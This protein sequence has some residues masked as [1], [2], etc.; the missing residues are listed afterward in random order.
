MEPD[1]SLS[2]GHVMSVVVLRVCVLCSPVDT[3]VCN[4][5]VERLD[6]ELSVQRV[7]LQQQVA[8]VGEEQAAW[9]EGFNGE[10]RGRLDGLLERI[11]ER[12]DGQIAQV[13]DK[14]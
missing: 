1:E 14:F 5:Q 7:Q 8:A 4:A 9:Q 3:L 13:G 12:L 2:S 10:L 11:R 6:M